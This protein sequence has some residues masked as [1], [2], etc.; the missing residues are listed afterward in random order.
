MRME[1]AS[2]EGDEK[3]RTVAMAE[4]ACCLMTLER[5]LEQ[6]ET[7]L[8]EAGA[9]SRRA[10]FEPPMIAQATGLLLQYHGA[11]EDAAGEFARALELARL[12]AERAPLSAGATKRVLKA[13]HTESH[14][15]ARATA[16][17]QFEDLWVSSD[18]REAE[19][20]FVDKRP[21]KFE[22]R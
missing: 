12:L 1:F 11:L 21:P 9:L 2:R 10:S 7:L 3:D 17:A 18:H 14:N 20:A 22:G 15:L 16:D 13:I 5:D 4:A 8:D 6:A 19:Q